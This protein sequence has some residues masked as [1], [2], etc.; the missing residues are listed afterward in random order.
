MAGLETAMERH[1][2]DVIKRFKSVTYLEIGVAYGH[3]LTS[4]SAIARDSGHPWRSVG[5]DLPKGYSLHIPTVRQSASEFHLGVTVLQQFDKSITPDW[6]QITIC[7]CPSQTLLENYWP[8]DPIHMALIDGC[9]GKPCVTA[10]FKLVSKYVPSGG[11]VAFHD[12]GEDSVGEPQPHCG[13]GDT[14]GACRELGLLDGSLAGWKHIDTVV[15]DKALIGR[16][17][18]VFQK[19]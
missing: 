8:G 10:D 18:G 16:D 19:L 11:L 2:N 12:F 5:I 7:L 3:T 15:G 17:L 9:H 14:L 6:N 13:L 1:L 4:M